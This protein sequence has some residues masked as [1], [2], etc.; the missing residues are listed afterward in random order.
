MKKTFYILCIALIGMAGNAQPGNVWD[1]SIDQN[2]PEDI[3][4]TELTISTSSELARLAEL[5]NTRVSSFEGKTI[6]LTSDLD[7]NNLPW[8]PIGL[9]QNEFFKGRFDGNGK[10]IRNL[11]LD[12]THYLNGLFGYLKNKAIISDLTLENGLITRIPSKDYETASGALAGMID[13]TEISSSDSVVIQNCHN[14]NIR[15]IIGTEGESSEGTSYSGGIVGLIYCNG[16]SSFEND[17]TKTVIIE[18]CTSDAEINAYSGSLQYTGGIV[19]YI[20]T[21]GVNLGLTTGAG[22]GT[23]LVRVRNNINRGPVSAAGNGQR[24]FAG[25]IVGEVFSTGIGSAVVME[26]SRGNSYGSIIIENCIN[27]GDVTLDADGGRIGG[28][29]A[30]MYLSG[31]GQSSSG[32]NGSGNGNYLASGLI[33]G[34]LN[35][36]YITVTGNNNYIGGITG[37]AN[38]WGYGQGSGR[39]DGYSDCIIEMCTNTADIEA[40]GQNSLVG[41]I[42]GYANSY[43]S[44]QTATSG[45]GHSAL[46]V[47][48]CY[49]ASSIVVTQGITGG[50]AGVIETST[51]PTATAH[52]GNSYVAGSITNNN[53]DNGATG[54]MVGL[55]LS[56]FDAPAPVVF[57]SLVALHSMDVMSDAYRIAG[58]LEGIP[59]AGIP[60]TENYAYIQNKTWTNEIGHNKMNGEDWTGYMTEM[61]LTAW[62]ADST[63]WAFD[64]AHRW[65]PKLLNVAFEQSDVSNPVAESG[66]VGI[67]SL[68]D[69]NLSCYAYGNS[70]IVETEEAGYLS[71]YTFDGRLRNR[72]HI[73]AGLTTEILPRGIYIVII[74]GYST[75]IAING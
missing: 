10:T 34:C 28:I 23:G 44:G 14:K 30:E 70:L 52:V 67:E 45:E 6:T 25:G 26:N 8:Q 63:V 71:I 17:N 16:Y 72:R 75:K 74:N 49:T 3:T 64:P 66:G 36:G 56:R 31:R 41:G 18:G 9:G 11:S 73:P 60:L 43:G 61:P 62:N 65:M 46:I 54:G 47:S 15:I 22:N 37:Y 20:N 53:G 48:D 57:N 59:Q 58:K 27:S 24:L 21:A 42:V 38:S 69:R 7:L 40:G 5:V 29:V 51:S 68:H 19:G 1:G 4:Q 55:L 2:W 13:A 33:K 35:E 12:N 50:L 39:R 32:G